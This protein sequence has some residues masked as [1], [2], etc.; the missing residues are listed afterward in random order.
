MTF[1]TAE[2]VRLSGGV[3]VSGDLIA[4]EVTEMLDAP[5]RLVEGNILIEEPPGNGAPGHG[6]VN[7]AEMMATTF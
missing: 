2:T 3:T 7:G 1:E 5:S 6:S 4:D